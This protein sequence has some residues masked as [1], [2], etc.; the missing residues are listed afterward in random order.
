[1]VV[2]GTVAVVRR[3]VAAFRTRAH[4]TSRRPST[5]DRKPPT[6]QGKRIHD[7]RQTQLDLAKQVAKQY[8]EDGREQ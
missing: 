1:L 8:L 5:S 7:D 6:D 2:I 4:E 3:V